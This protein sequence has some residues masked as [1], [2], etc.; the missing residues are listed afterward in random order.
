MKK[1]KILLLAT[2][3][4][5]ACVATDR[6]FVPGISGA[7]LLAQLPAL[8][9]RAEYTAQQLMNK[10]S[11]EMEVA[12]WV[13]IATAVSVAQTAYDAVVI[14]HGTD[15]MCYTAAALSFMLRNVQI[16]VLLTGSQKPSSVPDSDGPENLQSAIQ[17]A[18]EAEPGV[19]IAFNRKL[20][21]G[22]RAFKMYSKNE[23][24][25]VS[26]NYPI[27]AEIR[28]E[29]LIWHARPRVLTDGPGLSE[30]PVEGAVPTEPE[31][32]LV[33]EV[34]LLKLS[35][36]TEATILDYYA[37]SGCRG[38]IIEGFG[39]GGI[40]NLTRGMAGGIERLIQEHHIPVVMISQCPY[41][42]VNLS[43]YGVG[44]AA[45]QLGVIPGNDMTTETAVCKLM[46]ILGH[47]SDLTEIRTMV[48]Y[49]YL[50]E[51]SSNH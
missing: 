31:L 5:I 22:V 48:Q 36:S 49:N 32:S 14:T 34:G 17:F 47:T 16:P 50:D 39:A 45:R 33:S 13:A 29:E 40:A 8:Q 37:E 42:G 38:L 4:T 51:I 23:D 21:H 7:E 24:A 12:D 19:A 10:D 28:G 15:T 6:G 35:P 43:I 3:G 46:W 1:K 11:S 2:G 25:Y 41:D 27:L 44:E 18:L 26:R 20:I 30:L 9:E